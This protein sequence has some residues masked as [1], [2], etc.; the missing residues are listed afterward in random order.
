MIEMAYFMT[1]GYLTN[2]KSKWKTDGEYQ[3]SPILRQFKDLPGSCEETKT[4][5]FF[6]CFAFPSLLSPPSFSFE[7]RHRK[8]SILLAFSLPAKEKAGHLCT[9][10]SDTGEVQLPWDHFHMGSLT[11]SWPLLSGFPH[12]S[13]LMEISL[14]EVGRIPHTHPWPGWAL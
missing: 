13:Y 2:L 10:W 3:V 8:G 6:F 12:C 5:L 11:C 14:S 7:A 1:Y 9:L 4:L